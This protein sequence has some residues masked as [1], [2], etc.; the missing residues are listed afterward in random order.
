LSG[1]VGPEEDARVKSVGDLWVDVGAAN[2]AEVA[3]LGIRMLDPV[4]LRER[5]QP[6]A[7]GRVSG[8][9]SQ[10]RAGAQALIEILRGL[11]SAPSVAGTVTVAWVTQS[12][13]GSRGLA[14][15]AQQIQ[16]DR[17]YLAGPSP[18]PEITRPAS[19]ENAGI[20]A[21]SVPTLFTETPVEVVDTGDIASLA[22]ALAAFAGLTPTTVTSS[23]SR[24]GP[25]AQAATPSPSDLPSSF[26]LLAPL[27]RSYG[28]S[29]HEGPVRDVGR[30]AIHTRQ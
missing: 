19:W 5:A 29:G 30:D 25:T 3:Q 17:I 22:I 16:P 1:L 23:E 28:V 2:A 12:Q 21:T 6:L 10:L 26:G 4:S 8:V 18:T 7:D 20:Q 15:L 9:A 13:F 27:L 11:S 14:R 24:I